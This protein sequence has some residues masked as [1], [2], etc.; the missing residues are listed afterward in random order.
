[1]IGT[2]DF[3]ED[4]R[5]VMFQIKRCLREVHARVKIQPCELSRFDIVVWYERVLG[6]Q[7]LGEY[8]PLVSVQLGQEA[9]DL[10]VPEMLQDLTDENDIPSRQRLGDEIQ[11][12]EVDTFT[13]VDEAVVI[14]DAGDDI[15]GDVA[16]RHVPNLL[17]DIEIPASEVN[18]IRRR[19]EIVRNERP[20]GRYVWVH[21]LCIMRAW[22]REGRIG[23]AFA[24][25][26][27][28]VDVGKD[29]RRVALPLSI[30]YTDPML[31]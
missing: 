6:R 11:D 13:R 28:L 21:G 8:Q 15:A 4:H 31:G 24:P 2:E 17:P 22:T 27:A 10:V 1:M 20:H 25:Q 9:R 26:M 30:T 23:K 16:V 29:P 5:I 18:R 12:A 19:D 14:N 7:G 3:G